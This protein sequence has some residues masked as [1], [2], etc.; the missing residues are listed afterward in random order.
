[1]LV[2]RVWLIH[3][4]KS[5]IIKILLYSGDY[6]GI[7]PDSTDTKESNSFAQ[8]QLQDL[9]HSY[10]LNIMYIPLIFYPASPRI[11]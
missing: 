2:L 10:K 5:G 3:S 7:A 1:M 11:S 9:W 4:Y 6:V 8:L